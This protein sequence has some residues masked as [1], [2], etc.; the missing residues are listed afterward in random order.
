ML[1]LSSVL[2][3]IDIALRNPKQWS[4]TLY[5]YST[6]STPCQQRSRRSA[7]YQS[8]QRHPS[9]DQR[10][11]VKIGKFPFSAS[12]KARD[13]AAGRACVGIALETTADELGRI[14]HAHLT[15]KKSAMEAAEGVHELT[16]HMQ[17]RCKSRS[18]ER[19]RP[20]FYVVYSL[21]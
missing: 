19:L 21:A 18:K 11:D 16:I 10:Y 3:S 7:A 12:G 8:G 4:E 15:V 9:K 14:I 6:I 1:R 5:L 13:R 20:P 2:L 17:R